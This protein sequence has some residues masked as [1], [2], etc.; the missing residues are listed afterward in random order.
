[1][2]PG[3]RSN[4]G[5]N[6]CECCRRFDYESTVSN[7][8]YLLSRS[9]AR[10]LFSPFVRLQIWHAPG[11]VEPQGAG[12]L[13]SNH[14]S[15]FDPVLLSAAFTPAIDWRTTEEF[16]GNRL[17][18]VWLR[19]LNT[20]P[21]DR[22]RPDHR[23][24]RLGVERLRAGRIVGVFPE[25]GIRAG[26]TSV[27]GGAVPKGGATAL[28]RL[29]DVPIIPCVIFGSDRLYAAR[30]WRPGPPRIPVWVGIGTP[31]SVSH[32]DDARGNLSLADLMREI[33]ADTIAHFA[34]GPDDLPATPQHRKGRDLSA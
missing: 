32:L 22:S 17:G 30:N 33:G 11:A 3:T 29:A 15:H 10:I 34:L 7:W 26:A 13:V 21:V 2:L 31:F 19:A 27:F 8:C 12:V 23:A 6:F 4:R 20:F 5:R 1:V 18:A 16:Y 9:A 14:I 24:L 28:A 25:G